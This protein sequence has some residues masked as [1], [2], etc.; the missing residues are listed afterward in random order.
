[1]WFNHSGRCLSTVPDIRYVWRIPDLQQLV[2]ICGLLSR[3]LCTYASF[4]LILNE[5]YVQLSLYLQLQGLRLCLGWN[6]SLCSL[7]VD[8]ADVLNYRE[9]AQQCWCANTLDA[10]SGGYKVQESD[11]STTCS[12]GVGICGAGSTLSVWSTVNASSDSAA[13]EGYKGCYSVGSFL[14][15]SPLTYSG[16][17]MT[18]EL[19]RRTCRS[20]GYAV[21]GLTNANTCACGD[22]ANYG[23]QAAP[24]TCNAPCKGNT[25]E[26]C[27]ATYSKALTIFDTVGAGAQV[28]SGFAANY[29]GCISDGSPRRLS[30]Y[31]F[32]N[33]GMTNDMAYKICS[34]A[35]YPAY[36]TENGNEG[37]CGSS[38]LSVALLPDSYC[39]TACAGKSHD[40]NA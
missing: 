38:G 15:S 18:T 35:G 5:H 37:Y 7:R 24:A 4:L 30:A 21:A 20:A 10:T 31:S 8:R 27:G 16:D 34:A 3:G 1:M 22:S 17:Y 39:S 32:K 6:V 28:P 13:I 11:C 40:I 33:G 23:A 19:C 25:T 26:T 29:V 14:S 9:Y 12:G 2:R 36:G